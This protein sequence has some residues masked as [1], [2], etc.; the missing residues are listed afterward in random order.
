MP[1]ASQRLP[2]SE[3]ERLCL[4]GVDAVDLY[5]LGDTPGQLASD[6]GDL[7]ELAEGLVLYAQLLE[8]TL[9]VGRSTD[10]P[11]IR[12]AARETAAAWRRR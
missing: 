8:A 3:A 5:A 1:T 12:R 10:V 11:E 7:A 9:V 6:I 4:L 2:N